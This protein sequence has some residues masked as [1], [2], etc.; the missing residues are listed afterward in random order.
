V[1]GRG[2]RSLAGSDCDRRLN[3]RR[4]IS[5]D[6]SKISVLKSGFTHGQCVFFLLWK[7]FVFVFVFV[8]RYWFSACIVT[9]QYS[10]SQGV[11]VVQGLS[12]C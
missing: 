4:K 9:G 12:H 2:V 3:S 7:R 10:W 6:Y 11:G 5:A 1:I 8:F